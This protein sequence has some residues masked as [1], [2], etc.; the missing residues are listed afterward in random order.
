MMHAG[1]PLYVT[2]GDYHKAPAG[3]MSMRRPIECAM[4]ADI[5][6][7]LWLMLRFYRRAALHRGFHWSVSAKPETPHRVLLRST[8]YPFI[9]M[10]LNASQFAVGEMEKIILRIDP[11]F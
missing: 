4:A 9:R 11:L 3:W 1:G 10:V 5:A 7:R 2:P 6:D 8:K